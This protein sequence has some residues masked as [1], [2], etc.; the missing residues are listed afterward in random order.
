MSQNGR[1]IFE[2][3]PFRFNPAE[4]QLL[5][6][7]Q[8]V[9]LAPKAFDLLRL[10]VEQPGR[11]IEKEHIRKELWRDTFVEETS[12]TYHISM[13]RKALEADAPGEKFIETVPRYGYRFVA[14]V[15]TIEAKPPSRMPRLVAAAVILALLLA[16]AVWL[17]FRL[18]EAPFPALHVT[19]LTTY[20]GME[21]FPSLSPDGRQV[22]FAWDGGRG[23][24]FDIYVQTLGENVPRG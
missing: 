6:G 13:L 24:Q 14:P 21:L 8:P 5:R 22:A 10:L 19:P 16:G 15:R 11:L 2:F 4:R 7:V 20:P 1:Q 12:L 9:P 23:S 3:G 18:L 17:V